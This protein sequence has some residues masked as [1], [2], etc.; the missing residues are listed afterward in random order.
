MRAASLAVMWAAPS[1]MCVKVTDFG[2]CT[3]GSDM[4]VRRRLK[5]LFEITATRPLATRTVV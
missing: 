2:M 4:S 3:G 5:S 1:V